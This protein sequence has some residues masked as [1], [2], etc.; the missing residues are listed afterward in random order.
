MS[1]RL[2]FNINLRIPSPY[3]LTKTYNGESELRNSSSYCGQTNPEAM[4]VFDH[5]RLFVSRTMLLLL[6]AEASKPHLLKKAFF[7][8]FW[9]LWPKSNSP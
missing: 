4:G 8:Y 5:S 6:F 3:S 2:P 1:Y 9:T 7:G